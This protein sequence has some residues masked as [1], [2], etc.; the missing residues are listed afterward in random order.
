MN[1]NIIYIALLL[2]GWN[3]QAQVVLSDKNYIHTTVPQV[4]LTIAEMEN[5][6]CSNIN[7]I[8]KTIE[9]VTYFDGLGRPIQERAI[10]ASR[11]GKDIV[12]H[13]E[14][15]GYGRQ[16]KQY[17]PFESDS[18]IGAYKDVDVN[19]DI[20]Q[21]YK[22]TYASDFPGITD[23]NQINA[24]S[25]SLFDGSPLNRVIKVGAPGTAWKANPSS[26]ADHAIK[27][28]WYTNKAN[29]VVYHKVVFAN[30]SDTEKPSLVQDGY[31]GANQL[32]ITI[33]Q[34]ENWTPADGNNHTTKEYKDKQGRVVLKR[35]FNTGSAHDTYYVYDRFGKLTY[36]ISP[37]V[38]VADGVSESELSELCYQ[39]H[40]DY[41]NRLIEKKVP[42]KGKECIV[43]NK[44]DQLILTQDAN[45]KASNTWLFTKYDAFGRVTYTGKV[46]DNRER[47]AIQQ[48]VD[49]ESTLW[50][51]RGAAAMI[52]GTTV[53]Y[54]NE[55]FPKTN[56]ELHTI[57]YYDNYNFDLA[58]LTNPG[59]AYGKTI[60]DQTKT[61]PT[62]S[63]VRVL[64]TL[65]WITT[66]T[67]YDNKSRPIYVA[68]K[69]EYLNTT[70]IV[71][72]KLDF[73]GKV[74]ETKT[75]HTKGSNAAIV[76][77]DTFTYDHMGRALTQTQKINNQAVETIVENRYDALGQL[78][79]KK[80][81]GGLQEVDYTYNVRGWLTKIN[82]PNTAL[83]N[84]LFAFG[85]NY[86]TTT[87]NLG[88]TPLYNGNISETIWKTANYNTKRA[89]GY[90]YDALNRITEGISSDG[91]YNLSGVT[92]DKTGNIL[93]LNRKGNLNE[94]ANS[95]GDM[96][97]LTYTYDSGNKLLKVADTGNPTFGFKDGSNT[98]NDFAYDANGNMTVDN[99]KNISGIVYNHLN[100]PTRINVNGGAEYIN[101]I[102]DA[103]GTKLKKIATTTN[104]K[105]FTEYA[106]N[107][108]YKNSNLEFFNHSEGIVEHEA[109][110]YKYVYQFLDHVDN[111]RLSYK[112][113]N[114][115]GVITQDEIVQEKNYYPFGLKMRGVNETLRGR[116]HNYGFGGKE[117]SLELDINTYDFG[118][119]NYHPS[120]GRWFV[121]DA[122]ADAK[123]QI[124]NS[125]YAYA[126]NNPIYY[127]D[128]DG[129]CP[130]GVDCVGIMTKIAS[131]F[132]N[133]TTATG[134]AQGAHVQPLDGGE[135]AYGFRAKGEIKTNDLS[136]TKLSGEIS[137]FS[138][139]Y[140]D[141][142]EK[143]VLAGNASIHGLK[144]K[145][146][147]KN[148][149]I[150][151]KIEGAIFEGKASGAIGTYSKNSGK[152]GSIISG[153]VGGYVAKVS[154][155]TSIT[156]PDVFPIIGGAKIGITRGA[157][158]VSAHAGGTLE[159]TTK[160]DGSINFKAQVHYGLGAGFKYGFSYSSNNVKK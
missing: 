13:I 124:H 147:S 146:I 107:Y 95:F 9:N 55:A 33:T 145:V 25:E 132:G 77:I 42:G 67:R 109:D 86:N 159:A 152:K 41:R 7:D 143:G 97:I 106:G 121:I 93:S 108:I 105:I 1:K 82:D 12:T 39:Y 3:L 149:L 100:L 43:Y 32:Y 140:Q 131:F 84:K 75:T 69:N 110:G 2:I 125:P 19:I 120:L 79:S 123:G 37:K 98:G 20:N 158:F 148:D 35:V 119:R 24:Y 16:A 57:N 44:L 133:N 129:N 26:D 40:Y 160:Q 116:N 45:L 150:E 134:S 21:Y 126:M 91:N 14:Y 138:G 144:A 136:N 80:T 89:Y 81:G 157:T 156:L 47:K 56:L 135:R 139:G 74:E 71:E 78:E 122:L 52:D 127:I 83:G 115:D 92:Y 137:G 87:E 94:V 34:D 155:N 10:K 29:E 88:A 73:V 64:E 30:P 85:I 15:D 63:K 153:E 130:P 59:T 90:Q 11:D 113:A 111:I 50:E 102:Y 72:S 62:G 142:S 154:T 51:Q 38:N 99:N 18:H 54:S 36:V 103:A 6:N 8:N 104:G 46:T 151:T 112:D 23:L 101:Y 31:Y 76:T 128:P 5:V 61:L 68:S 22:D 65:D 53:Y 66:V 48:V 58:G 117:Y 96:D 4:A 114:K 141:Q 17:L 118:A 60:S 28:D 27:T 49:G 70:D